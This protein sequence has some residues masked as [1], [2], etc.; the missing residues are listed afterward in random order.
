MT[1][2]RPGA[3]AGLVAAVAAVAGVGLLRFHEAEQA[4]TRTAGRGPQTADVLDAIGAEY[5]SSRRAGSA[6]HYVTIPLTLRNPTTEPIVLRSIRF[7][8]THNLTVTKVLV[9]GPQS[10]SRTFNAYDN[11]PPA[12]DETA[13]ESAFDA[14]AVDGF[15]IEPDL[16]GDAEVVAAFEDDGH[17]LVADQTNDASPVFVVRLDDPTLDASARGV[18]V[19]FDVDGEVVTQSFPVVEFHLCAPTGAPTAIC[20]RS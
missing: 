11:W 7:E 13:G 1:L 6:T 5:F 2:G 9:L 4:P 15:V 3:L 20:A 10:P 12:L 19:S 14:K 8:R 16:E 18:S 17:K